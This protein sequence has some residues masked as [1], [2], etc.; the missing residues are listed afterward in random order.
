VAGTQSMITS[1]EALRNIMNT[2]MQSLS[3]YIERDFQMQQAQ[4]DRGE[5]FVPGMSTAPQPGLT[6]WH[7]GTTIPQFQKG[8]VGDFGS[9]TLALLHGLEAIVPLDSRSAVAG[10]SGVTSLEQQV[11]D[12]QLAETNAEIRRLGGTTAATTNQQGVQMIEALRAAQA[13]Y[14]ASSSASGVTINNTFN[15]NGSIRDLAQPLMDELTRLMKQ[16]RLWPTA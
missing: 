8:G 5:F 16:T 2:N 14:G 9:G 10:G 12:R 15:V 3:D 1:S 7:G 4:R 11:L 13:T 6:G